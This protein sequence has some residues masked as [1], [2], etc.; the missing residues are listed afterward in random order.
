MRPPET[1]GVMWT[2][3]AGPAPH[4]PRSEGRE[5]IER[6]AWAALLRGEEMTAARIEE[7]GVSRQM[8]RDIWTALIEQAQKL[9]GGVV[10]QGRSMVLSLPSGAV[11]NMV[12]T[13]INKREESRDDLSSENIWCSSK[14][15]IPPAQLSLDE[16][17][18]DG[19]ADGPEVMTPPAH[20]KVPADL[21]LP[22]PHHTTHPAHR[23]RP[24]SLP[25]PRRRSISMPPFIELFT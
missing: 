22:F 12:L 10:K 4:R 14:N 21:L 13:D 15:H 17:L 7:M 19:P 25:P 1:A 24:P 8:A 16:Q 20:P 3:V 5:V 2:E 18:P 6:V 9:G 11:Q 23:L